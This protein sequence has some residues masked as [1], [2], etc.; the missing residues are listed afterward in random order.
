MTVASRIILLLV[1]LSGCGSRG[2]QE[3]L[4]SR[5]RVQEEEM[6]RL[7]SE[8]NAQSQELAYARKEN[9]TLQEKL[10][11]TD[12][13]VSFVSAQSRVEKVV[14]DPMY[15]GFNPVGK[16]RTLV[17]FFAPQDGL[18]KA[19]KSPGDVTIQ[20]RRGDQSQDSEPLEQW[21]MTAQTSL[22]Y[23]QDG[24]SK[25]GYLFQVKPEIDLAGVQEVRIS[26]V[27]AADK[28]SIFQAEHVIPVTGS[29]EAFPGGLSA[30][31]ESIVPETKTKLS[32]PPKVLA[33][34]SGSGATVGGVD[35]A[36]ELDAKPTIQQVSFKQSD[37]DDQL[38]EWSLKQPR[39]I[40]L[41]DMP[42][43]VPTGETPALVPHPQSM[44]KSAAGPKPVMSSDNWTEETT[45]VWR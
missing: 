33:T 8:L 17:L 34:M 25:S 44:G 21:S 42:L 15:T 1:L 22:K 29:A 35:A 38:P 36:F 24:F 41:G 28:M 12:R 23:W 26:L 10:G 9:A 13:S 6:A 32:E 19:V 11:E 14:I 40:P 16:S 2:H 27:F 43:L 3:V 37:P 45:P 31:A 30:E 18:G 20:L 4:E 7:Q 39:P 5:L